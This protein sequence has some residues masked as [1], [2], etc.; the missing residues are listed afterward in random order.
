MVSLISASSPDVNVVH[1]SGQEMIVK[2]IVC[3]ST[4]VSEETDLFYRGRIRVR[5]G[6]HKNE[7]DNLARVCYRAGPFVQRRTVWVA[8][9]RMQLKLQLL[10]PLRRP[11]SD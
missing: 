11:T 5:Y 6:T 10:S 9:G 8:V 4:S 2:G 1:G 3:Q 7:S